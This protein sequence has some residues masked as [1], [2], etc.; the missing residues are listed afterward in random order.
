M[1]HRSH[2]IKDRL[3]RSPLTAG[4]HRAAWNNLAFI[5]FAALLG[6]C[7]LETLPFMV[8]PTLPAATTTAEEVDPIPRAE[9]TIN[10]PLPPDTPSE[11]TM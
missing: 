6:A 7:S 9:I 3:I 8:T 10:V 5:L 11:D 4:R 1:I 2:P